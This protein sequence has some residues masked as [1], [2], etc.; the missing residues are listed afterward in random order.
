MQL[1][2][3][4]N[5][6]MAGGAFFEFGSKQLDIGIEKMRVMHFSVLLFRR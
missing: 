1:H 5:K 3:R 6:P 2:R 4:R